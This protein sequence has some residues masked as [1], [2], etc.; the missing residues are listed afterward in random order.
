MIILKKIHNWRVLR[1]LK[2]HPVHFS[3]W[4]KIRKLSCI[5]NLSSVEKA[6]L[7]IL[8]SVLLSQKEFVGVQGLVLTDDMK[9][10]IAAQACV[11]IFK[12]GLN[13]Y[14]S[15]IQITVYPSAFW[16]KRNEVDAAGVVHLKKVL[17]SGE[18]WTRGPVI[19]SWQDIEHDMLHHNRGHN[20]IIHEFCHKI[21]MLNRGANGT[22]PIPATSSEK[23]WNN[24]FNNAYERLL[25]QVR[26][27]H[28]PSINNYA[29]QSPIEFFAVVSEYFFTAPEHLQHNYPL[30][31]NELTLFYQQNPIKRLTEYKTV[32]NKKQ[33]Y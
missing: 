19:L 4:V 24:I 5:I 28:K 17:L 12:L 6:R 32:N 1:A 11:P 23:E 14:S 2:K 22:P 13:Y 27:H 3:S 20:V 30:V 26:S 8:T 9:L 21:D 29:A 18:S 7:R 16:V 15:F 31:Y 25:K 33:H 10:I